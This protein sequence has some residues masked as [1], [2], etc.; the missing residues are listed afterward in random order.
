MPLL[1]LAGSDDPIGGERGNRLLANA[2]RRAGI[3][4]LTVLIY[5]GGRHEMFNETNKQQVLEDLIEWIGERIG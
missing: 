2:Y 3:T 5:H 4:D 1:Q